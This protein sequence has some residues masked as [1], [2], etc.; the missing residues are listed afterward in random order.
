MVIFTLAI[1]HSELRYGLPM[2]SLL[3][4]FAG[5]TVA[6]AIEVLLRRKHTT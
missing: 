6:T 5:V 1:G 2:Q 4:V 3:L